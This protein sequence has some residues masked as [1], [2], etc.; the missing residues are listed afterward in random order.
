MFPTLALAH[1]L[2][3]PPPV[4]TGEPA[5]EGAPVSSLRDTGTAVSSPAPQ[6]AAAPLHAIEPGLLATGAVLAPRAPRAMAD[7]SP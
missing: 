4:S 3:C 1:F 6:A 2:A 7:G 5:H